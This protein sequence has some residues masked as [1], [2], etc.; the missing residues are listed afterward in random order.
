MKTNKFF[1]GLAA[2]ILA[3]GLIFGASAFKNVQPK[4]TVLYWYKVS[5]D[6]PINHPNGYIKAETDFYS[7]QEKS[8][9]ISPCDVGNDAECLRGF[10]TELTTFPNAT[11]GD[12]A[13]MRSAF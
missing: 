10:E 12:D 7:E 1:L 9:V 2:L 8:L 4:K 3:F 13:I 11:S 5:Y 6:D